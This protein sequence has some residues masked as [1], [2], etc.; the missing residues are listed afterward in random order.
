MQLGAKLTLEFRVEFARFL[1]VEQLAQVAFARFEIDGADRALPVEV[2]EV[3]DVLIEHDDLRRSVHIRS[4]QNVA[5][6]QDQIRGVILLGDPR[7][8]R[9]INSI[10]FYL[11]SVRHQE[12]A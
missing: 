9:Q 10:L 8:F 7:P 11:A 6:R 5:L 1:W 12:A 4:P 2:I 3:D